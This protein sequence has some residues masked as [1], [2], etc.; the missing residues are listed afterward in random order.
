MSDF[1]KRVQEG[2]S[3][4][5]QGNAADAARI[6]RKI[7]PKK[8]SDPDLL[9]LAALAHIQSDKET[10]G[11]KYL[12]KA[13]KLAPTHPDSNNTMGV[14][15][16]SQ[17]RTEEAIQAFERALTSN[18]N[19]ARALRNL[20]QALNEMN[21]PAEALGCFEQLATL[22]PDDSA[23]RYLLGAAHLALGDLDQARQYFRQ[24]LERDPE[25]GH[26]W[27]HL[28]ELDNELS[29]DDI[30]KMKAA[31][32]HQLGKPEDAAITAVALYRACEKRGETD[33]AGEFLV[34]SNTLRRQSLN[35]DV[36]D[37]EKFMADVAAM[38]D[39]DFLTAPPP[40]TSA[41]PKPIFVLGLPRSGTTLVEQI[42]SSHSLVGTAGE[43]GSIRSALNDQ[44]LKGGKP[45]PALTKRLN[46]KD[47]FDLAHHA[48]QKLAARAPGYEQI[49]DKTPKNFVYLGLI[50]RLWPEA[51]VIHCQRDLMD[52]AWSNFRIQF[53][54]A[55]EY[56]CD[57]DEIVRYFKAKEKLM[58]H[59]RTVCPDGFLDLS[60]EA[61]VNDQESQTRR[62]LDYCG[63]PWEDSCLDFHK[64]ESVVRTAS[65]VQVRSPI[66]KTSLKAW[67]PYRHILGP[68]I[69]GLGPLITGL[70]ID[71][72]V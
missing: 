1:A 45:F 64:N 20:G 24:A 11:R 72:A 55:N 42:L 33:Q 4:L 61:L 69:T 65:S 35:Y 38:M 16:N 13:L 22:R 66:Y 9:H 8:V 60:Y 68:M 52:C 50:K 67:E 44:G 32:Q 19:N 21:R 17:G 18:S 28:A 62:L 63:L 31:L 51:A 27:M 15:L 23:P 47:L 34:Q 57:Q 53:A 6:F 39:A 14:L 26:A 25:Y 59:W 43:A 29:I 2:I 37:D 36:A 54:E 5:N 40:D 70:S 49:I 46:Q 30:D 7:L 3:A 48:G 56:A 41:G 12:V 71:D 58:D 10:I